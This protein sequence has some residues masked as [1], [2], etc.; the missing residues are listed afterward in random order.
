[1]EAARAGA[2]SAGGG[3]IRPGAVQVTLRRAEAR[4][5]CVTC[6]RKF[7]N[8]NAL[9]RHEQESDSHRRSSEKREDRMRKR[10]KELI[11]AARSVRQQICDAEEALQSQTA[12]NEIMQNQKGVLELQL[13]Q[14]LGEYGQA[15]EIIEAC[16]LVRE[17]K[18]N[19]TDLPRVTHEARVGKL[20]LSAG[21][22]CWQSNKDVQED[23]YIVDIEFESPDGRLIAGFAVLD[24][25]SGCAAVDHVV[26]H[27]QGNLQKCMAT[28]PKL[29]DEHLTKSVHEAC[30]ITDDDFLKKARQTEILDGSTMI[31][32]LVYPQDCAPGYKL[33]VACVGDSRAVLCRAC[34]P[35]ENGAPQ[36]MAVPLSDD[37]KPN[38]PDE[39]KRVESVGGI[40]DFEGVWRVFMPGQAKFG[41]QVIARWGLAVSR[42]F[43]D[44]LLKEPEKYD[45]AGVTPGGLVIAAPEIRITDLHPTSDR[46]IVLA[47]D[48]VWDVISNEDAVGICAA[49]PSSELAAQRLLRH[50]YASNTDDNITALVVS[51]RPID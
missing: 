6:K 49:Q 17:A 20:A 41:G 42:A 40:V 1:M 32:A 27:L 7:P 9:I 14:L 36:L 22:A 23:R 38:R 24:G 37:H 10:K 51:W 4:H 31:L 8:T 13:Q 21:V 45:C 44:L 15:Q 35:Q 29:T 48:G 50:V 33:L 12:V 43:G 47:S 11:V 34:E 2:P 19:D 3:A 30:L 26:E 18:E 25:H 46:F 16:R 28:K 39:Q 5:V